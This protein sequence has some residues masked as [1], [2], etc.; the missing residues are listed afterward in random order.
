MVLFLPQKQ[1]PR[2]AKHLPKAVAVREQPPQR[3]WGSPVDGEHSAPAAA[4]R[5]PGQAKWFHWGLKSNAARRC[6]CY[7]FFKCSC[8]K[9]SLANKNIGEIK[10]FDRAMSTT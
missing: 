8:L 9:T 10:P 5:Y 4:T 3:L 1:M 6:L 7:A 2:A